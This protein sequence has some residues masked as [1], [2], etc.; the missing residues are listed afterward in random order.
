MSEN[1]LPTQATDSSAFHVPTE[2]ISATETLGLKEALLSELPLISI[3]NKDPL[4]P[5]STSFP[6]VLYHGTKS[7][8]FTLDDA[9]NYTNA[10][11]GT[12][13][14]S[15]RGLYCASKEAAQ[16]FGN[17]AL[18]EILPAEALMLDM[19]S[20]EMDKP[21]SETFRTRLAA[22]Q[23]EKLESPG[24]GSATAFLDF[25]SSYRGPGEPLT[26]ADLIQLRHTAIDQAKAG[27]GGSLDFSQTQK[28][29]RL[30]DATVSRYNTRLLM[31]SESVTLGNLFAKSD[32]Q[33]PNDPF[34]NIEHT[35][36][37]L[38]SE[39]GIDGAR[40]KQQFGAENLSPELRTGF[41]FW[42]LDKAGDQ[43]AWKHRQQRVA[44]IGT[45]SIGGAQ[46]ENEPPT[47]T[48]SSSDLLDGKHFPT[49]T[50]MEPIVAKL[51]AK[52]ALIDT[53]T[54]DR[55]IQS[56][57]TESVDPFLVV[58]ELAKASPELAA[59]LS[60]DTGVLERYRLHEHTQ[61]VLGQ[62]EQRYAA[63]PKL[64][65]ADRTLLRTALLLQDIGKSL[66][67]A[68]TGTKEDQTRYNSF[69]ATNILNSISA[70][71][72]SNDQKLTIQALVGH[73]IIGNLVQNKVSDVEARA[74]LDELQERIPA[75]QQSKLS[76][77]MQIMY[78]CDVRAY[79][80]DATYVHSNGETRTAKP[81]L[82]RLFENDGHQL[83]RL[84]EP[85]RSRVV[86]LFKP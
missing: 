66:A 52:E 41:V 53:A 37:L 40:T 33:K 57:G 80:S 1:T 36:D 70:D 72:L 18:V 43:A 8:E 39:L 13:A 85:Q 73:D 55:L 20:S 49:G 63:N 68:R 51:R 32:S 46:L 35:L 67:V 82:D 17:G 29:S 25:V 77:Y 14:R 11:I 86:N 78:S 59:L 4:N 64:D 34:V 7:D 76:T 38:V 26:R 6:N 12:G 9:I 24:D 65:Q 56:F 47:E 74:K 58:G 69:V 48:L 23:T 42:K 81:V 15:G 79:T 83:G 21:L 54:I 16:G 45:I 19:S 10:P 71:V 31:D 22:L 28:L 5:D 50:D 27:A 2:E 75:D 61:A 84:K 3:G 30:L 44:A 62:F 60:A